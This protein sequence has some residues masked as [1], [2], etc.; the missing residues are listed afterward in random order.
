ME[1]ED[2]VALVVEQVRHIIDLKDAEIA[3]VKAEL[4]HYREMTDRRLNDLEKGRDD[5]EQRIR[6][7]TDGVT[8]F[9]MFAGLASG[10]SSIVA[11]IALIKT[12]FGTP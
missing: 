8:Q 5:H 9:K 2:N 1:E 11:I 12:F 4:G 3:A 6:S 7:V 10:G